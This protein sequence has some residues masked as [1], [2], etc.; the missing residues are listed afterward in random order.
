MIYKTNMAR[1][2]VNHGRWVADCP[3]TCGGAE[4]LEAGQTMFAC[5]E[6]FQ[7]SPVDWPSDADEIW[8][9]LQ[10]RPFNR[11]RHWYP[12]QHDLAVRAGIP[13]GQTP[14][15]LRQEATEYMKEMEEDGMDFPKNVH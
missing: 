1:A 2:Y 10:E 12:A 3:T 6:C 13:H 9:A 15:E 8:N 11:V 5:E 7:I 14:E 4:E